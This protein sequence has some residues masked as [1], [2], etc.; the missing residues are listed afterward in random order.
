M[1]I[2][3]NLVRWQNLL[4]KRVK[5]DTF[6][7]LDEGSIARLVRETLVAESWKRRPEAI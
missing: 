4:N 5:G 2:A 1:L 3:D 7:F 6:D